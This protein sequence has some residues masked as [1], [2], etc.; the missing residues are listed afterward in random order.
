MKL[1]PYVLAVVALVAALFGVFYFLRSHPGGERLGVLSKA[2]WQRM[3]LPGE[4]SRAHA[5]LGHN[6]AVCHTPVKGVEAANCIACHANNESLLQRQPTAF[7]SDVGSCVE[8]HAEHRGI[9]FRPTQM[10]HAALSR[11]GLRQLK[12]RDGS[13]AENDRVQQEL[14]AWIGQHGS[15]DR[16]PPGNPNVSPQEAVLNCATCHA[17][18][19]RHFKLFGEDCA[20]CH[21][22][23]MWTIPEFRHPPPSS[24][25]CAQCHQAPPSH[26]MEHFRLVSMRVA[27]K[28]HAQVNQCYL[29]HQTTAWNDIKGVGFYKHH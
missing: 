24:L 13:R 12:S 21:G 2:D 17:S 11:I 8:C 15:A 5:F 23:T 10:D 19:D 20:H 7:H 28:P 27:G 25:D 3:A 29:C 22:T 9:D 1:W 14:L 18:K 26:Y 16:L 6:C 4:L